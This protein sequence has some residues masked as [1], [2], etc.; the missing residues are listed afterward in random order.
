MSA[1]EELAKSDAEVGSF[2]K[3]VM[4]SMGQTPKTET[5]AVEPQP[6]KDTRLDLVLEKYAAATIKDV[7]A[8]LKLQDRYQKMIQN[9]V[10]QNAKDLA[11]LDAEGVKTLARAFIHNSGFT[12]EEMRQARET[13]VKTK[14]VT[15]RQ[16][17]AAG[18]AAGG[19]AKSG[20]KP[21]VAKNREEWLQN[22][23][24]VVEDLI[25]EIIG[26]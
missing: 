12:V 25:S 6:A 23:A 20:A 2:Y 14:P 7:L 4:S 11:A 13:P 9:H 26:S 5:P 1:L 21:P 18:G 3:K 24:R 8:P 15:G 22:R 17:G 10:L 19:A 16:N